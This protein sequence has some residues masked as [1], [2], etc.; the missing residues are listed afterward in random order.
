MGAG[1]QKDQAMIKRLEFSA[2]TSHSPEMGEGLQPVYLRK[3]LVKGDIQDR[4]GGNRDFLTMS[5]LY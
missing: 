4:I 2:P 5:Y 3:P 1:H